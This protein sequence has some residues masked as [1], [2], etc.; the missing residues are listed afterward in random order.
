MSRHI[1]PSAY[2][3]GGRERD[4]G[5]E[6]GT[7][8]RQLHDKIKFLNHKIHQYPSPLGWNIF[9]TNLTMGG[10]LG[11][12]SL[13]CM[14]S[15]KVP[16]SNGVSLGLW[17][18]GGGVFHGSASECVVIHIPKYH[19]IPQHDVVISGCSTHPSWRVFLESAEWN[20]N[21]EVLLCDMELQSLTVI[22]S[23][24]N[25]STHDSAH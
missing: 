17:G 25:D 13:N 15:L 14:V 8:I 18:K 19:S 21:M 24:E 3:E 2:T 4:R 12:S 9:E 1:L 22:Q 23:A 11:Y 20:I 5:R 10:L 16:S 6:G 7:L